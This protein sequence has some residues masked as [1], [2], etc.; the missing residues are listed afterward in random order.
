VLDKTIKGDFL[1]AR[2]TLYELMTTYGMSGS[3]VVKLIH[4]AILNMDIDPGT[5][6]ELANII[7]E[8]DFRLVEGANEDIQLSALLAQLARISMGKGGKA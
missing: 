5:K 7:G 3:E 6:V 8:Y 1:G 4:R 2:D